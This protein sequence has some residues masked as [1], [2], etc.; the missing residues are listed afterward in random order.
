MGIRQDVG[1]GRMSRY[2]DADKLW[3]E[4][5]SVEYYGCDAEVSRICGLIQNAPTVEANPIVYGKWIS[6]IDK[7]HQA[8]C[9]CS[10][11]TVDAHEQ[12]ADFIKSNFCPNCGAKMKKEKTE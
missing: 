11:C 4:I 2:I 6:G 10:N 3:K 9:Y 1:D 12:D 8:Y 7:D 5:E